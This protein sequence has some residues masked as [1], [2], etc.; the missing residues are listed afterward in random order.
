MRE[1]NVSEINEVSGAGK[2]QDG[3]A[4]FFGSLFTNIFKS[5][6]SALTDLGYTEDQASAAGQDLGS[7][8]GGLIETQINKVIDALGSLVK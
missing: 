8:I 6:S 4:N 1:L 7:R 5:A 2:I 3:A